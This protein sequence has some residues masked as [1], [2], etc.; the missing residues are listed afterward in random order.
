MHHRVTTCAPAFLVLASFAAM[1][2]NGD[3]NTAAA[4]LTGPSAFAVG[5]ATSVTAEPAIIAAEF[6]ASAIC[7]AEAPF[8]ARLNVGVRTRQELFIRGFGFEFLDPFGR[9]VLPLAFP[10]TIAVNNALLLPV[11]LPTTHPI[12]FPGHV[13]MSSVIL[14][15]GGLFKVPFRL[16]FDCGV[17]ARGTLFVSVETGDRRG[18]IDVWRVSAQ[19]R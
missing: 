6:Q 4:S 16:R 19:I 13:P 1:A 11:S 2:C 15:A 18:T 8:E 10:G 9:R 3:G 14:P 12:P 5:S 17:P 7:R